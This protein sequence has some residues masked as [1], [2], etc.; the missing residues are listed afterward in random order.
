MRFLIFAASV[1]G[2]VLFVGVSMLM[3]GSAL[4]LA[5]LL[6]QAK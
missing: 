5:V 6:G 4:G 2:F 1:A 3:L